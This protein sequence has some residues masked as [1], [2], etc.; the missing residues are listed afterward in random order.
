MASPLPHC[1]PAGHRK[2]SSSKFTDEK[3]LSRPGLEAV[4]EE[5]RNIQRLTLEITWLFGTAQKQLVALQGVSR[6]LG[7]REGLALE[8]KLWPCSL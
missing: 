4:D 5:E 8:C 7:G 2:E 3:H 1:P 6:G